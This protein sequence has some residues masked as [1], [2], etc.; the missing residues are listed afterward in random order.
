MLPQ[1]T[2]PTKFPQFI[3]LEVVSNLVDDIK[4]QGNAKMLASAVTLR[5]AIDAILE[6]GEEEA[7]PEDKT[8]LFLSKEVLFQKARQAAGIFTST[9]HPRMQALH[10]SM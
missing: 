9:F 7:I 10:H 5:Q 1:Q 4:G 8:N 2:L 3:N 6:V